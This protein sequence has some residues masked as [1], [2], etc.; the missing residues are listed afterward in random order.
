M[1]Q[2][3]HASICLQGLHMD[4][5]NLLICNSH[6]HA[7][8]NSDY[9]HV[10]SNDGKTVN[11]EMDGMRKKSVVAN[12]NV[13]SSAGILLLQMRPLHSLRTLETSHLVMRCNI[14]K[15]WGLKF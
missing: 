3:L 6:N 8:G 1:E 14:P 10:V 15:E 12:F 13:S 5:L 2:Y 11:N 7:V 9:T 4:N